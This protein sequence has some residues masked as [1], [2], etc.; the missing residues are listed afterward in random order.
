[1]PFPVRGGEQVSPPTKFAGRSSDQILR[2]P[3]SFGSAHGA[4]VDS[5]VASTNVAAGARPG[6]DAP[7]YIRRLDDWWPC[8]LQ[9]QVRLE[10]FFG[11]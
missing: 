3:P 10:V 2:M 6:E 8:H 4:G 9:R 7:S 5:G 11:Q 1:M